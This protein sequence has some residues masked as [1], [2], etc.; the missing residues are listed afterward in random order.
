MLKRLAFAALAGALWAG[1]GLAN[2]VPP[3]S[4]YFACTL[5]DGQKRVEF[6]QGPVTE[7]SSPDYYTYNLADG[8]AVSELYF[9]ADAPWISTKYF[10]GRNGNV[11][12]TL[13]MALENK[14][15]FYAFYITGIFGSPI[16]AAQLH[17]FDSQEAFQSDAGETEIQRHY[18]RPETVLVDWT[19]VGP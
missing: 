4:T 18:C 12:E 6:C 11:S 7:G 14:G 13:G 17:V 1:A 19:F 3:A 5:R 10:R 8:A 16:R 9:T 2:C 15:Y